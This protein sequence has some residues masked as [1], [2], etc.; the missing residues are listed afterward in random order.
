MHIIVISMIQPQKLAKKY[1]VINDAFLLNVSAPS[2]VLAIN[3]N[4]YVYIHEQGMVKTA[5]PGGA[6]TLQYRKHPIS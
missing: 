6:N 4:S 2:T 5:C 3:Y 1:C